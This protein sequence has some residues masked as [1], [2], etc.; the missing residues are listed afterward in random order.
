[1]AADSN[2]KLV[3]PGQKGMN[4]HATAPRAKAARKQKGFS[5]FS[6]VSRYDESLAMTMRRTDRSLDC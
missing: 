3:E 5:I 4:G 2:G 1:M 6:T